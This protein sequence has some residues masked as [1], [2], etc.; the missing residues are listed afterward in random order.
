MRQGVAQHVHGGDEIVYVVAGEGTV[1]V[2]ETPTPVRAGSL[3]V[4]PNGVGHAF[5]RGGKNPLIV[6]STLIGAP[7][8][9]AD[10]L[11]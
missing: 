1:R 4:V 2:G 10:T 8:D 11:R 9:R 7:C 6:V 5:E 3:V